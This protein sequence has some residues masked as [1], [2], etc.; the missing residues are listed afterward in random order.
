MLPDLPAQTSI[1]SQR[2]L[3]TKDWIM[4]PE[5]TQLPWLSDTLT[6]AGSTIAFSIGDVFIALGTVLLLWSLSDP[7]KSIHQQGRSYQDPIEDHTLK[8]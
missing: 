6:L 7:P 5:E 2:L 3:L 4:P 8:H 1:T